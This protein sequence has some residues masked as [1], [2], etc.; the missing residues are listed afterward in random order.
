MLASHLVGSVM[1]RWC[2]GGGVVVVWWC[3]G[4]GVVWGGL[5]GGGVICRTRISIVAKLH[6]EPKVVDLTKV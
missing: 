1:A 6:Q 5:G 3:G 4:G 2:G